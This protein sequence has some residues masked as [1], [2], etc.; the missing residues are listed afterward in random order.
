M[1]RS[2]NADVGFRSRL[3]LANSSRLTNAVAASLAFASL[4]LCLIVV[5]TV[6]A[7]NHSMAMP[8]PL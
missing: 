6:A 4:A 1:D 2:P 7:T 8:L 3:A 5:M